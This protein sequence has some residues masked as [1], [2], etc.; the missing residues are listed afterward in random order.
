MWD[1][2]FEV[3]AHASGIRVGPLAGRAGRLSPELRRALAGLPPTARRALP[4]VTHDDGV[5]TL[6]TLRRDP[7]VHIVPLAQA[8]LAGACG[9]IIDEGAL[10]RMAKPARPY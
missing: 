1:G 4:L 10:R 5:A 8:R 2:R 3:A 6:P 9:A 7:A